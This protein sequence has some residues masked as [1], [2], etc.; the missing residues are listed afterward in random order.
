MIGN[1]YFLVY[2]CRDYQ[3]VYLGR[4]LLVYGSCDEQVFDENN[5]LKFSEVR[6][7][8]DSSGLVCACSWKIKEVDSACLM[9][10]CEVFQ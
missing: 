6:N 7:S 3:G 9:D 8:L 1:R 2:D 5:E 4:I 10:F